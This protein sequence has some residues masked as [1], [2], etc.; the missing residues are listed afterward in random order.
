[1]SSISYLEETL[2]EQ[3]DELQNENRI[4]L[5]KIEKDRESN[6]EQIKSI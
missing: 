4:L 1:M 2:N 6:E 3:I 5:L